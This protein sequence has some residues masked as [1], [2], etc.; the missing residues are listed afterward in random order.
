VF[1]SWGIVTEMISTYT[2]WSEDLGAKNWKIFSYS[3]KKVEK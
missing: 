2:N 1:I 3:S